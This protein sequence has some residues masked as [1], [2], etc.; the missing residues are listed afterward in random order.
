MT[1]MKG[2]GEQTNNISFSLTFGHLSWKL[3]SIS[4]LFVRVVQWP[5]LCS[6]LHWE[7]VLNVHCVWLL[8]CRGYELICAQTLTPPCYWLIRFSGWH[9]HGEWQASAR[10]WECRWPLW[11]VCGAC[12]EF[13]TPPKMAHSSSVYFEFNCL[14]EPKL[15][16]KLTLNILCG[17]NYFSQNRWVVL[18]AILW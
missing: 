5:L 13:Y 17:N 4:L 7:V 8:W 14:R 9:R 12:C 2:S 1:K 11:H 16:N 6:G 10:L 15:C 3:P 18:N